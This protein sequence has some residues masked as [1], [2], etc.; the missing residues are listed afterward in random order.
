MLQ[1]PRALHNNGRNAGLLKGKARYLAGQSPVCTVMVFTLAVSP[2]PRIHHE[3][4]P[5]CCCAS[6]ACMGRAQP[7]GAGLC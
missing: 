6:E 2:Q 5:R 1:H 4:V 7:Q 3:G